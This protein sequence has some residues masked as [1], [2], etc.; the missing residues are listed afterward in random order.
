MGGLRK[1][2]GRNILK[3]LMSQIPHLV[4]YLQKQGGERHLCSACGEQPEIC[5]SSNRADRSVLMGQRQLLLVLLFF[6]FL[7][8]FAS[9]S[10]LFPRSRRFT[11]SSTGSCRSQPLSAFVVS[12]KPGFLLLKNWPNSFIFAST[13]PSGPKFWTRRTT[14]VLISP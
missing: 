10:V 8:P 3:L 6:F 1:T 7:F 14:E 13:G 12:P 11:K 9:W 2:I 4:I 5:R